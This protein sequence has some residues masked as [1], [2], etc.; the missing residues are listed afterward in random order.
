[1]FPV[2]GQEGTEMTLLTR[3]DTHD[4]NVPLTALYNI[5]LKVEVGD[6]VGVAGSVGSGK[7][8]LISALLGQVSL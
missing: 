5:S 7:S 1:M 3:P 4:E 6:V 2:G 8:A